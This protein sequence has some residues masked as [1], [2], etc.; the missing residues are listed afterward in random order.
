[1]LIRKGRGLWV[2]EEGT[3]FLVVDL[4]VISRRS[5]SALAK[6]FGRRLVGGSQERYGSRYLITVHARGW[7][8]TIDQEI[9]ELVAATKRLPRPAR[10]LWDSAQSREFIIGIAA[11]HEPRLREFKFSPRTIA[12]VAEV[13][14]TIVITV[15]A[16]EVKQSRLKPRKKRR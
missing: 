8:Q 11:E 6:A 13:N 2:Q 12:L 16:P 9:R 10:V 1:M 3:R 14:A 7:N 5:L 15:Y 4:D